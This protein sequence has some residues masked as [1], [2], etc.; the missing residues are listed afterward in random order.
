MARLLAMSLNCQ[1]GAG[2]TPEPCGK[3][4]ACS[5]IAA[6]SHPDVIELDA[7]SNR[8]IDEIRA[9][10]ENVRLSPMA[11]RYKVYIIDEAHQMTK[12]AYNA[13]LK[14]LEEPPAHV[15]FVLATT[16]PEKI[17]PTVRSRCQRFDFRPLPEGDIVERLRTV[18]KAEGIEVSDDLLKLVARKAEGSLRDALGLLEQCVAFA[19]ERPSVEDFLT[20]TGGLDQDALREL[21]V[22]IREGPAGDVV[23]L[24]DGM[25]RAGRD[26]AAICG[27]LVGYLRDLFLATL[28]VKEEAARSG[29]AAGPGITG[30]EGPGDPQLAAEAAAWEPERLLVLI[31]E[32]AKTEAEMRYSPQPRLLLEMALLGLCLDPGGRPGEAGPAPA[33]RPPGPSAPPAMAKSSPAT[34][35]SSGASRPSSSP[36]A[37]PAAARPSPPPTAPGRVDLAW[38]RDNWSDLLDRARKKSVFIR[39]YLLRAAPVAFSDGVLTLGFEAKFHK[40]QMEEEKNRRAFE[41][42][43]SEATG[44]KISLRCRLTS[45]G[46]ANGVG[47]GAGTGVGD[48]VGNGGLT[49]AATGTSPVDQLPEPPPLEAPPRSDGD[50]APDTS[51]PP[52]SDAIRSALSI[53]GGRVVDDPGNGKSPR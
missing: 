51:R 20:V 18:A 2:P 47:N 28:R 40:E 37:S 52:G 1:A 53:F 10:Q 6:G 7:A 36:A 4:E 22:K 41:E 9:L 32:L 26:P 34:A 42:A 21:V 46:A 25:L 38:L 24:L 3:C 48:D 43:L 39:A 31:D 30:P 35:A 15:V 33:A 14:T 49:T 17:L 5:A 16:E 19:G 12:D 27:G 13:F 45:N 23:A 8:G 50:A 44:V 11:G 29:G